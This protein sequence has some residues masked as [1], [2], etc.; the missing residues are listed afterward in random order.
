MVAFAERT[1]VNG[2]LLKNFIGENISIFL[3]VKDEVGANLI[4]ISSD[5][6]TITVK[7]SEPSGVSA[8]DWIEVQGKALNSTTVQCKD[9]MSFG[10]EQIDFDKDACDMMAHFVN[11][12][13]DIFA[14]T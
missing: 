14:Y 5:N 4:G 3:R 11:N 8:G 13:K 7:V 10:G 6:Q 2:S 9:I 12:C 1:W